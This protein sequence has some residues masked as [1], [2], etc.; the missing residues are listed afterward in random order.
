[1]GKRRLGQFQDVMTPLCALLATY[2]NADW[3]VDL[4][5][6]SAKRLEEEDAVNSP[7]AI[8]VEAVSLLWNLCEANATALAV[9][10]RSSVVECLLKNLANA[11]KPLPD[12]ARLAVMQCLYTVT[13]DN[14]AAQAAV[15]Q[16]SSTLEALLQGDAGECPLK[17]YVKV[18][19]LGVLINV[20]GFKQNVWPVAVQLIAEALKLDQR[21]L[22]RFGCC[23]KT[24][25]FKKEYR[26]RPTN[27]RVCVPCQ[28]ASRARTDRR[29]SRWRRRPRPPR[30]RTPLQTR[31]T[32]RWR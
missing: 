5:E 21:Q 16:N 32:R 20:E 3:Q 22:V 11:D 13:E 28:T 30:P 19:A 7:V 29:W 9:F 26:F 12:E 31:S 2:A 23:A 24:S 1:M 18:L 10:N 14:A 6:K 8:F 25:R 27:T 4:T 15:R 17:A